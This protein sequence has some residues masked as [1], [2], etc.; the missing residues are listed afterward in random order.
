MTEDIIWE[1]PP[2]RR[3]QPTV[4][5]QRLEPLK[6]KPGQWARIKTGSPASMYSM[7]GNLRNGQVKVPSG[8]WEFRSH[9]INENTGGLWA[10]YL[11]E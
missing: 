7:A 10:R 4:W 2:E 9:K 11:G 6:Q 3:T 8:R 1:N 5:P